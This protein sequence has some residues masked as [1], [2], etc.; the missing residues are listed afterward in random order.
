MLLECPPPAVLANIPATNCPIKFDQIQKIAFGRKTTDARFDTEAEMLTQAAWTALL[1]ATDESKIVVSPYFTGLT[2]PVGEAIKTGGNDNTTIN[3][4]S[5]LQGGPSVVVPF[6]CKNISAETA[7]GLRALCSETQ[8]QPGDTN[9]EGYFFARNNNI[10]YD[11]RDTKIQGFEIFNL[12]VP[13]VASEGFNA[14]NTY[15]CSFELKFG[16]SEYFKMV[17]ANFNITKL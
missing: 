1:A 13:D 8:L 11:A 14:N 12:F 3:G 2:I 7:R 15:N 4:I 10:I 16:W 5:E 9:L 17:K 6:I